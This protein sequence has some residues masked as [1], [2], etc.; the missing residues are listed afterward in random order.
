MRYSGETLSP[1]QAVACRARVY[2][3]S[4]PQSEAAVCLMMR[5]PVNE[6]RDGRR[7]VTRAGVNAGRDARHA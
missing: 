2:L 7:D 3:G 6:R 1:V 4:P 5:P